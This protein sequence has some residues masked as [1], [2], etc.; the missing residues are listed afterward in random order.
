MVTKGL[1]QKGQQTITGHMTGSTKTPKS[2]PRRR[3]K[4]KTL[5]TMPV[6]GQSTILKFVS[7]RK[8]GLSAGGAVSRDTEEVPEQTRREPGV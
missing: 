5:N 3:E 4:K 1:P 7:V 6:R 8:T 2:L